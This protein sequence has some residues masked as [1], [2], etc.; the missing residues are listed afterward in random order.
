MS[1]I[2]YVNGRY[3]PYA[4]A[5]V[6]IEDRGYQFADAVYE[7]CE[8]RDGRLVDETRHMARLARSLSEIRITPPVTKAALG[9]IMREVVRRNRVV[10]GILYLQISRGVAPRAHV[11]PSPNVE[12]SLV[13]IAR[14]ID[15]AI[16]AAHAEEGVAVITAPDER[17]E[18]VDIKTTGLLPNLLAKQRAKEAGA[19]EAWL[20]DGDGFVTEGGS[21]NAWIVTGEGVL[22]TRPATPGILRGITRSVVHDLAARE[23]LTVE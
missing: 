12:P 1:R 19:H 22:V 6:P 10:N 20:L 7:A 16:G 9:V 13:V 23:G 2:A 11:F 4:E 18:R 17:W 5:K 21:T 15:P 8:V 3:L 14:A